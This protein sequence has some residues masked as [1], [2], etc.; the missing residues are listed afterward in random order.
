MHLC[1]HLLM[2]RCLNHLFGS[3]FTVFHV[4]QGVLQIQGS[5]QLDTKKMGWGNC[6]NDTYA[7]SLYSRHFATSYHPTA[8]LA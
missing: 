1:Q 4:F 8:K 3:L 7:A 6:P 5:L 2:T